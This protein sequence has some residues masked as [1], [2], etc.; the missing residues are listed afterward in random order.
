[1]ASYKMASLARQLTEDLGLRLPSLGAVQGVDSSG[2]ATVT[3]GTLGAG[4][5]CAFVRL[6]EQASIQTDGLG[7]AQRSYG[8]H[9]IQVVVE[10]STIAN[11]ALLTEANKLKFLGE[12]L[13]HGVKVE[14][15][16]TANTTAPSVSGIAAANLKATWDH[17]YQP[18]TASL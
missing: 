10:T 14:L 15:Y 7:L 6:Q 8:P 4:N 2:N 3:L 11:V 9:V 18:L 16:M 17:L 12:C 1:M 5:Q 13:K